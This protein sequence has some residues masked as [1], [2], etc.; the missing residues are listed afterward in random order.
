MQFNTT[1]VAYRNKPLPRGAAHSEGP[2]GHDQGAARARDG[3]PSGDSV[4]RHPQAA[5][6]C[7]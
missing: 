3:L 2:H 6:D 5:R 1:I 7:R 4:Q